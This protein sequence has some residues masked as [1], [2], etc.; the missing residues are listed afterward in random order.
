MIRTVPCSQ[1]RLYRL[2]VPAML[3]VGL[4]A[5]T[6]YRPLPLDGEAVLENPAPAAVVQQAGALRH[7]LIRPVVLDFS[8]PLSLDAISVMAVVA[9]PDLTALRLQQQ[10]ATAQLFASGLFPDPQVSVGIDRVLA[11]AEAG[12]VTGVAGGLSLDVLGKL[13]TRSVDRDVAR[14]ASGQLR[15]DLAWAEWNTAGNARLLASRLPYLQQ[16]D[17]LSQQVSATATQLLAQVQEAAARGDLKADDLQAQRAAGLDAT[18]RA[19]AARKE[20]LATRLALNRVL[21]LRPD[22]TLALAEPESRPL[23][24]RPAMAELFTAARRQR[25]DLQALSEGYAGQE[26]GLK[27]AVLGQYPRV[28]LTLNRN[29]DTSAVH[30]WGPAVNLDLPLWNRNRGEIA[31]AAAGRDLLRA[32]FAA[33]LHQTRADIVA[34]ASALDEDEQALVPA[35]A[36]AA[37]LGSLAAAYAAA[38]VRGDLGRSVVEAARLAAIDKQITVLGL[39]QSCTEQRIALALL[40]GDPF[41]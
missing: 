36:E 11:P 29:R 6:T 19:T 8:A 27:R 25:L 33:R 38:A 9:N 16:V 31:Q 5:C 1:P 7:A 14:R 13:F 40:T 34:L 30:S 12:L 24:A 23:P 37:A 32:E 41:P 15:L 20:L 22:T 4:V 2:L 21:G 17:T 18:L 10:V 26:A 35:R 39:E 28:G 3:G